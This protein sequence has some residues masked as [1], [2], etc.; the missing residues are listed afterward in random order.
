[1]IYYEEDSKTLKYVITNNTSMTSAFYHALPSYDS[2]G[3]MSNFYQ[4]YIFSEKLDTDKLK[5]DEKK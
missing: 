2:G 4:T 1:M 3:P 5:K